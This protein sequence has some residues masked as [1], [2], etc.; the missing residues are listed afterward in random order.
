MNASPQKIDCGTCIESKQMKS[1]AT[2]KLSKGGVNHIIHSDIIGPIDPCSLGGARY[3]LCFI[4]EASRYSKVFVIKSRSQLS[5]CFKEFK[6]W[7][8][9]VTGTQIERFH[10]DNAK[11]YVALGK[12]LKKEGITQTFSTP[13]TPQSNGIAERFNRTLLDKVRAML[14]D[15]GLDMSFW[16]EAALHASYLSNVTGGRANERTT[17]HEMV[18]K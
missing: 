3:I 11:E 8:E 5:Q 13:Y 12:Y 2:G 7:L 15:A 18:L 16:G 1:A 10:S 14:R 4:V 9:R 6:A 17:P